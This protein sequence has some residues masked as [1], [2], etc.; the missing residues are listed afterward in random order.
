AVPQAA[1]EAGCAPR[2]D[3]AEAGCGLLVAHPPG[4]GHGGLELRERH[5]RLVAVDGGQEPVV[6]GAERD[7]AVLQAVAVGI[8]RALRPQDVLHDGPH[9]AQE[10]RVAGPQVVA[11][12]L[13]GGALVRNRRPPLGPRAHERGA[14]VLDGVVLLVSLL[15]PERVGLLRRYPLP[16]PMA[17]L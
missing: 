14:P 15:V 13:N 3:L 6:V 10:G 2:Q 11:P 8:L 16:L 12:Y 7:D 4:D 1:L 17:P 9:L 5:R